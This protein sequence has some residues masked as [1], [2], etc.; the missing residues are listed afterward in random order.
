MESAP[1]PS[2]LSVRV[3]MT[4]T[5]LLYF[6]FFTTEL[7]AMMAPARLE[8]AQLIGSDFRG[9]TFAQSGFLAGSVVGSVFTGWI[10]C[11]FNRQIGLVVSLAFAAATMF[12]SPLTGSLTMFTFN[13]IWS[14]VANAG[15]DVATNAWLLEI[16]QEAANPY[17]QGLHFSYAFGQT[18]APLFV[19]PFLSSSYNSSN[20]SCLTNLTPGKKDSRIIIPLGISALF[21]AMSSA[22]F[23]VI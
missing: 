8:L 9:I 17:M 18:L 2:L 10:F 19:E 12:A 5:V 4:I 16:W 15:I 3:K 1:N 20:G 11:R 7:S 14:G 13:M 23:I 6:C 21:L 22:S